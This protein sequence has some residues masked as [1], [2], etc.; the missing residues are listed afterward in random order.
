MQQSVRTD[1]ALER[2][3]I[4]NRSQAHG[5]GVDGVSYRR[6][7]ICGLHVHS[8]EIH[9]ESAAESLCKP[10]GSYYT[11]SLKKLLKRCD[12]GFIDGVNCVSEI[13]RQVLP[14]GKK[15]LIAC[16]GNPNIT[17]DAIGP[18]CAKH[19]MVTRHLKAYMPDTFS[20][21]AEVS[22]VCPGV[23]GTTGIE[24]ASIVKGAVDAVQPDAVI[25]ID[26][27]AAG[28]M[29][30]LCT[31]IQI[32]NTGIEPGSGVG[33]R[34]YALNQ[35][36]LGIPVISAGVPTIVDVS[37]LL[38]SIV[39]H[40]RSD[41]SV[42]GSEQMMVTPREIDSF[43]SDSAKLLAYAVNFALHRDLTLEDVDLFVS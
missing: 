3:D 13:L 19:L 7:T 42:K 2:L 20:D 18:L 11:I 29:E 37:T 25:V 40:H 16:L 12:D 4:A 15:F 28:S 8:M 33:N 34:R 21:F 1:M 5:R 26:A 31:T 35:D 9:T 30:R 36:T 41:N 38:N 6:K 23:L 24:S 32:S 14:E 17:P 10:I 39:N 22:L 27:L 43:V